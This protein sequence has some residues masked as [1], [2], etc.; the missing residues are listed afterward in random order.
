MS[1]IYQ[2][3]KSMFSSYRVFT[4]KSSPGNVQV[5]RS[6]PDFKWLGEKLREEFPGA[7]VPLIDKGELSKKVIEEH[8]RVILQKLR[9]QH[10][11]HLAYFLSADDKKFEERRNAEEGLVSSL[12]SRL[13]KAP[14]A[15]A[16]LKLSDTEKSKV[17]GREQALGAKEEAGL[18]LFLD[19]LGETLRVNL[20]T[21][22][23]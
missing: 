7:Q 23:Q 9:L 11:R 20:E 16:D 4:L 12:M 22:K 8:F 2:E 3:S 21:S 19:E 6:R 18:Q 5:K 17:A 15:L 13:K 1:S 10:S 14:V